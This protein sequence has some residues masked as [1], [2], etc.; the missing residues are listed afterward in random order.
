MEL[1]YIPST[2]WIL[3]PD[4]DQSL[5]EDA[6]QH[7]RT[8]GMHKS[9]KADG[10]VVAMEGKDLQ[11]FF[12]FSWDTES[13]VLWAL[14]TWVSEEARGQQLG[15][16]M[17]EKVL[18][19]LRPEE[20]WVNASSQGGGNLVR[21]LKSRYPD[22]EWNVSG[23]GRVAKEAW[24]KLCS[25]LPSVV[26]SEVFHWGTLD[27][28]H[29]KNF[30]YEGNGL[31]V[32]THP[33]EWARITPLGGELWVLEK[34]GGRFVSTH[35]MSEDH[36]RTVIEWGEESGL[37]VRQT[38]FE[39]IYYDEE[40]EAELTQRFNTREEAEDEA[41]W[42]D[43]E[44]REISGTPTPSDK[45]KS[46]MRVS[47]DLANFEDHLLTLYAE[48]VTDFDGV[49]WEDLVDVTR[50]SAPRGV[51]LVS[52][53]GEWGR[54]KVKTSSVE[55]WRKLVAEDRQLEQLRRAVRDKDES[56]VI[57]YLQYLF[58]TNQVSPANVKELGWLEPEAKRL[59]EEVW[60]PYSD[61]YGYLSEH[62]GDDVRSEDP[63]S[64][65]RLMGEVSRAMN[66]GGN[67][68]KGWINTNEEWALRSMASLINLSGRIPTLK[69]AFE[70]AIEDA[71]AIRDKSRGAQ[72][73]K[74]QYKE[75]LAK[76]Q[77]VSKYMEALMEK[78]SKLDD[79]LQ[80]KYHEAMDGEASDDFVWLYEQ[81]SEAENAMDHLFET[82]EHDYLRPL[83]QNGH[84]DERVGTIDE[85][86]WLLTQVSRFES[87]VDDALH[88][89][90]EMWGRRSIEPV[91]FTE[92]D[93]DKLNEPLPPWPL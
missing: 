15:T 89:V 87:A 68:S 83:F 92:E 60:D 23:E 18:K 20:V 25:S 36:W 4:A 7:W 12:R 57:P 75:E 74:D 79:I 93:L 24:R 77:G 28:S 59:R 16:E 42:Q 8:W 52:K 48:S 80:G 35:D 39:T 9:I 64:L 76:V 21:S 65:S 11:G 51:I 44:V 46:L 14:G 63:N 19:G 69:E 13:G 3:Q 37:V 47:T 85:A 91:D 84:P 73:F 86:G 71:T 56:A 30:S 78:H 67:L 62:L 88:A 54:K 33:D 55:A 53:L 49:W 2:H 5:P 50:Y 34:V 31:S 27:P 90:R 17:W 1:K 72:E 45:M 10:A 32:T 40:M 22:I 82:L 26:H 81:L 58:R 70:K 66:T 41:E 43:A 38:V 61:A 29:K 6:A